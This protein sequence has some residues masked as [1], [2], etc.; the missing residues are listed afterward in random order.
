M[1]NLVA[2]V[3][4]RL[5]DDEQ[6]ALNALDRDWRPDGA[7]SCQV[8]SIRDEGYGSNRTIAWCRNGHDD[9]FA[10]A[11]HIARHDPARV[12]RDVEA[13]RRLLKWAQDR[14]HDAEDFPADQEY[15]LE[16][17]GVL[18]LHLPLLALP[19]A[20]HPDYRAEWGVDHG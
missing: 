11:L 15:Q 18:R 2:F 17:V 1:D 7:K 9:D 14:L 8:Y 6:G 16:A 3:E 4:A 13:K 5:E 19:Y 12:L 20:D 10:N